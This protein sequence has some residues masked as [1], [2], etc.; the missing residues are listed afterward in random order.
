MV[1]NSPPF[2][3][4]NTRK[5]PSAAHGT[6]GNPNSLSPQRL[7]YMVGADV[8]GRP[9]PHGLN[10]LSAQCS[11]DRRTSQ[12]RRRSPSSSVS[13]AFRLN[14]RL[15]AASCWR[16]TPP[17]S[18]ASLNCLSAQCSIDSRHQASGIRHQVSIAFRLNVRLIVPARAGQQPPAPGSQLP[19]GSMFD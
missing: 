5:P 18:V 2:L 10:C 4:L 16:S 3:P 11:I 15:I 8:L 6:H 9:P 17:P 13:I 1:K 14:V 7:V 12:L 19:F